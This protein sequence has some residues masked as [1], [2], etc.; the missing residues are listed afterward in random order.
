MLL[1]RVAWFGPH[2]CKGQ[3]WNLMGEPVWHV[4]FKAYVCREFAIN[5]L[6]ERFVRTPLSAPPP[7][8]R[9]REGKTAIISASN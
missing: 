5:K 9:M 6:A 1:E 8:R 3:T 7:P 4:R 2:L